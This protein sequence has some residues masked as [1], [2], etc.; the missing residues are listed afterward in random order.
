MPASPLTIQA[1]FQAPAQYGS[2]PQR[3]RGEGGGEWGVQGVGLGVEGSGSVWLGTPVC[4][5]VCVCAYLR[6]E[7][8]ERKTQCSLWKGK[9]SSPC[10][11]EPCSPAERWANRQEGLLRT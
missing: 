1:W 4:V 2:S 8:L 3:T 9:M 10:F 7:V 5:C 11:S 6:Y